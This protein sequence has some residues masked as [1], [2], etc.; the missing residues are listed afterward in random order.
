LRESKD[1]AVN[2]LIQYGI[3]KGVA[4]LIAFLILWG[5]SMAV[6]SP[7]RPKTDPLTISLERYVLRAGPYRISEHLANASGLTYNPQTRSLFLINNR[8]PEIVE[9]DLDGSQKR[10]I[11]LSGFHDTEGITH[12]RNSTF[13]VVEEKRRTICIFEIHRKTTG[14][15]RNEAKIIMVDPVPDGNKGLEGISYDPENGCFYVVKEKGPRKIYRIPWPKEV[16]S[17]D[18]ISQPFDIQKNSLSLKDL[19]GIYYHSATNNIL[20]L[21]DESASVVESTVDGKELSRLS[22][23]KSQ[24]TGLQSPSDRQRGLPWIPGGYCS[25]LVNLICSMCL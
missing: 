13:A 7:S 18:I 20:V 4:A 3:F 5:N 6:E 1:F 19:S 24:E 25:L 12:I 16:G 9:L 22:L 11:S 2:T 15:D 14:I 8:P 17:P 21:S 10:V 23:E